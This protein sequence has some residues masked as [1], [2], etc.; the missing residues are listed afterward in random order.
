MYYVLLYST[1]ECVDQGEDEAL[2]NFRVI[3][4]EYY[5][6]WTELVVF[7]RPLSVAILFFQFFIILELLG[8]H[9][10]QSVT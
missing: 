9:A 6:L 1:L 5:P 3:Y 7:Y 10:V 8:D 4:F 2:L